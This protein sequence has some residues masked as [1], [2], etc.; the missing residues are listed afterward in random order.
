[1]PRKVYDLMDLYPQ[2]RGGRPSVIYIPMR[3][4]ADQKGQ[5]PD[6]STPPPAKVK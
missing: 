4:G 5:A 6:T 3:R 2:G 1:M